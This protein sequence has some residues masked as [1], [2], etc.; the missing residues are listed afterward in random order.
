[1]TK[2]KVHIGAMVTAATVIASL[3]P[4]GATAGDNATTS[5][6]QQQKETT[7]KRYAQGIVTDKATGEPLM[8]VSVA[9][10]QGGKIAN[11]YTTDTDGR[12]N[13]RLP[14]TGSYELRFSYVGYKGVTVGKAQLR[15]GMK[16][17]LE[18]DTHS[19]GDVVVNGYFSKNKS[20]FT[21]AVTQISEEELR[22]VS[23]TNIITAIAALTPGLNVQIDNS[24]GSNPNHVPELVM[25]GM[26]SFSNEGQDVN[27]P[28]IILDGREISM[29]DLYD[30]DMNEVESINVLKDASAT[31]L[32]GSKAASGVIVITRKPVKESTLRVTYNFT[33][34][35][36][37]PDFSDYQILNAEQ[38]LEYERLAGLYTAASDAIDSDTGLPLQYTY[39]QLY[40]QRYQAIRR[41]QNTDWMKQPARTAFSH[42]HSLRIYGGSGKVRYEL[43]ARYADTKGVMKD[44]YRHRY[45]VGFNLD[46]VA[47]DHFLISNRTTYSEVSVKNTPYGS[48]AQYTKMN[49]YDPIYNADGSYNTNMTWEDESGYSNPLY[50]ASLGSYSKNG[51]HSL[52]STTDFRWDISK[53]FRLT[54]Q[55]D[56][57]SSGSWSAIYQ[58]PDSREFRN[59]TDLTKRG[60]RSQ[61]DGRGTTIGAKLIGSYNK[62]FKDK[63]LASVTAG[64]EL[65]H[66]KSETG[67]TKVV[68]FFSDKLSFIGDAAGYDEGTPYGEQSETADVGFFVNG[69]YSFRE[70]YI[71]DGTWRMTGSSQFGANERFGNF[72]STGLAWNLRNES[73][74]K[75][76]APKIDVLKLRASMGYTGKVSFSPYQAITM[77][78]YSNTYEYKY[79]IGAR[80]KT[81]GNEDLKW[82]RTMT[83]N[84]GLDMSL[85]NRRLNLVV[86]YYIKQT[87]DLLLD[88]SKA[89]STG[90]T[91]AKENIG[92]LQ[93]KGF[94]FQID[95]YVFRTKDF[96][97]KL[98][99]SGS[100]NSNKV[101]KLSSALEELNKKN[102]ENSDSYLSPL[103]QYAEGESVT[104]L[105]LVRS[106]GIDPATG[107]EIYIKRDGTLTFTYDSDDKVYIGDTQPKYTGTASTSVYWKG[108]SLYALF[109]MRFGA[110]TYNTTRATKVEGCS[111]YSNA[112]IRVFES[113]WKQAGDI[114][115]YKDISD[116]SR[117]KQTDRFAEE[118]NTLTLTS[119]NLSYEF[120][121]AMVQKKLG[122][123]NLRVGV[124]FTDLLRF[125]TI[126]MERGT[127]Y[128]YS[129]GFEMTL[130]TTF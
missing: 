105:K 98:G 41:G 86:D 24:A 46:Y 61:S 4:I 128:L 14:D 77:Y 92:E 62:I 111:P 80:P 125:S 7:A 15:Q 48:F 108:F 100:M 104:A 90:V 91:E 29:Q 107:K 113:R 59:E 60:Y 129:R 40:N 57:E 18:E 56:I 17:A 49:P 12:F 2:R 52:S 25:R 74:M 116:T 109:S 97:W 110:W 72:W 95:G 58:S 9:V 68:G 32:Y 22:Q 6:R 33:G 45:G 83:Y 50:E 35:L 20:S 130:N 88:K 3:A 37:F 1:M 65:N 75:S 13:L 106:A 124:N 85:F 67:T 87:K 78:E 30:L 16:V 99:W 42:D 117:P 101:T 39:D 51:T 94:E 103:P 82:E 66:D 122:L 28:T 96:Y 120:P 79:G 27:Q 123:R 73:F 26:S 36:Q 5:E 121:Q 53:E 47:N 84:F 81:I 102:E 54:G 89:P 38:K 115:L 64:W 127:E 19:I 11:G 93:N 44:D 21:G 118:E 112:D 34:N 23:G 114:A 8:G 55:F 119:L 63:S 71:V 69:T 126:K 31:A 10:W 70:R 43:N 76:L